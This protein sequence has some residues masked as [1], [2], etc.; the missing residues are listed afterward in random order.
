M[1]TLAHGTSRLCGRFGLLLAR[2]RKRACAEAKTRTAGRLVFGQRRLGMRGPA[3]WRLIPVLARSLVLR[4]AILGLAV[5]AA[6]A[7]TKMIDARLGGTAA[8]QGASQSPP[9]VTVV[10]CPYKE[11]YPVFRPSGPVSLGPKGPPGVAPVVD[12]KV[13]PVAGRII[14]SP[15]GTT[16][17]ALGSGYHLLGGQTGPAAPPPGNQGKA[18]GGVYGELWVTD[19]QV[20][21]CCGAHFVSACSL[22]MDQ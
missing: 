13:W 18:Y 21:A 14:R 1:L 8:A 15:E 2:R 6:V 4:I 3:L 11:T 19:P 20:P 9:S 17:P 12:C 10:P 16:P 7:G 22:S 5:T